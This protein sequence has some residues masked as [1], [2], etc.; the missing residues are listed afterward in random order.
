MGMFLPWWWLLLPGLLLTQLLGDHDWGGMLSPSLPVLVGAVSP[1]VQGKW[2]Q[3]EM[4]G[5]VESHPQHKPL[6][7]PSLGDGGSVFVPGEGH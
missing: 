7:M 5:E 1:R 4:L 3:E 6:E 2:G